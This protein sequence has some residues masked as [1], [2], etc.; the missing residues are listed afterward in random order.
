M[1][2]E[3]KSNLLSESLNIVYSTIDYTTIK[4]TNKQAG[5][6]YLHE[7]IQKVL[8]PLKINPYIERGL[9]TI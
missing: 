1:N 3:T 5:S 8:P 9:L 4:N 2:S 7:N 6:A